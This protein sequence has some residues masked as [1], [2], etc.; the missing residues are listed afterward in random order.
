MSR[1]CPKWP[2]YSLMSKPDQEKAEKLYIEEGWEHSALAKKFKVSE[3]TIRRWAETGDWKAKRVA[4]TVAS[5]A[6]ADEVSE[7]LDKPISP[8]S[9]RVA[10]KGLDRG[11]VFGIA[12]ATLHSAAPEGLIKSQ[13]AAYGQ[14]IKILQVQQQMEHQDKIAEIEVELKRLQLEKQRYEVEAAR[15]KAHPVDIDA[16]VDLTVEYKQDL[17]PLMKAIIARANQ[18]G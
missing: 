8:A 14:L 9:V 5:H 4:E 2:N 13:E 1:E 15:L 7:Q 11:E 16:W 3:R 12:I 18:I 10:M 6:M 17:A